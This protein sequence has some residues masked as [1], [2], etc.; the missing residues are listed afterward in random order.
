M[1]LSD[2]QLLQNWCSQR[3]AITFQAIVQ[4]HAAMVFHTALRIL[5]NRADAEDTS[6]ACFEALVS[7]KEPTKIRALGA[8]LHGNATKRSLNLI[9]ANARRS[10]R[11]HRYVEET[12]VS[13]K[14]QGWEDIYPLIDEAI[15]SL[16]DQYRI[17]IIAHFLEGRSQTAIAEEIDVTRSAVTKRIHKGV[18][19][20]E[21]LLKEKGIVPGAALAAVMTNQLA[22]ASRIA[23]SLSSSLGKLALSQGKGFGA[24]TGYLGTLG[25]FAAAVL[26]V[27]VGATAAILLNTNPSSPSEPVQSIPNDVAPVDISQATLAARIADPTDTTESTTV[28]LA[29]NIEDLAVEE[30]SPA[31]PVD[32]NLSG[33][34]FNP[35]GEPVAGATVKAKWYS[36]KESTTTND[37]GRFG[38]HIPEN[39]FSEGEFVF[40][41]KVNYQGSVYDVPYRGFVEGD[42]LSG[43]LDTDLGP[44]GVKGEREGSGEGA[45]GTWNTTIR[46]QQDDLTGRLTLNRDD[47]GKVTGDWVDTAGPPGLQH[48]E[49]PDTITLSAAIENAKAYPLRYEFSSAG[50]NDIEMTLVGP[51][52]IS[53]R[54]VD[55]LGNSM[56]NWLVTLVSLDSQSFA[57]TKADEN[58][59]FKFE[60]IRPV[61]YTTSARDPMNMKT[62]NGTRQVSVRPGEEKTGVKIV[63]DMGQIL[64][65]SITNTSG[66]PL[67]GVRV[68]A[69]PT[70]QPEDRK[71]GLMVVFQGTTGK[72]GRYQLDGIPNEPGIVVNFQVYLQGYMQAHVAG[73]VIDGSERDFELFK[74]ASIEGRIID[75][76]TGSPISRFRMANWAG[77][78]RWEENFIHAV[79]RRDLSFEPKGNFKFIASGFNKVGIAVA[80]PGYSTGIHYLEAVG[81]GSTVQDV[82]IRLTPVKPIR[83]KVVDLKGKPVQGAR[84][85]VGY[86]LYILGEEARYASGIDGITKTDSKG[87]FSITEYAE[88]LAVVS[89]YK[90]GYGPSWTALDS[91]TKPVELVL[92]NGTNVEGRITFNGKPVQSREGSASIILGESAL[93]T[94]YTDAKGQ[95][96]MGSIPEGELTLS[97]SLNKKGLRFYLKRTIQV[98]AGA[99][100]VHEINF[101]DSYDSYVE[102]KLTIAGQSKVFANLEAIIVFDNGDRLSYLVQTTE[103]GSYR[104]GPIPAATFEFGARWIALEDGSYLEPGMEW[105]TTQPRETTLHDLDYSAL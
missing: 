54:V 80:A 23:P 36:G 14:T 97:A 88:S 48:I 56:P 55:S 21:S 6:Q 5:G 87:R 89:T 22:H 17:P 18:A 51:A 77:G 90:P 20:I 19:Q 27:G 38:F 65:G 66:E 85:Y 61:T 96:T 42:E 100:N 92:G 105:V 72:D 33:Y 102:G 91:L 99:P 81:P 12:P 69:V 37:E 10:N 98:T 83:G 25:K 26:L 46:F 64:S 95:F 32:G 101:D 60:Y 58:G 68:L 84:I 9:R 7:A 16:D 2:Q 50:R 74:Q 3:D 41:R 75:A 82:E 63:Y 70:V 24:A 11:E 67:E 104:L 40:L 31:I 71:D 103:D 35:S 49:T 79:S 8:W 47:D 78:S 52:S 53:G 45:L 34:V 4:R 43:F 44:V 15:R 28:V 59:E 13:Q 76:T 94:S 62:T 73:V 1:E 30:E 93:T 29:A 86:P 39:S 57:D